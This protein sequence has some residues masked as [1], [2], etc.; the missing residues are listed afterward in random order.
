MGKWTD[1]GGGFH[2]GFFF[3]IQCFTGQLSTISYCYSLASL[4]NRY[5]LSFSEQ[6]LDLIGQ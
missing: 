2:T 1:L 6:R 5:F 3:T 4:V